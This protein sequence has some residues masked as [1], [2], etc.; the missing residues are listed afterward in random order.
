M[1]LQLEGSTG[2][3]FSIYVNGTTLSFSIKEFALVTSLKC[4]G[5][6]DNFQFD[7][8]VPNRIVETYFGGANLVKKKDLLTCFAEKNWGH[9]NDGDAIK[10]VV[11]Y[12]IHIFIFSSEKDTTTIPRLHFD[13]VE[14]GRFSDY[15]WGIKAF[16]NLIKSISKKMD[17]QKKYYRIARMPLAMQVWF[18]E[19]CSN[20]DPKIAL[21]VDNRVPRILN[22]RSTINQPTYAYMMNGMFTDQG[23]MIVYNDIQPSDT[24]L[25]IIQIPPVGVDVEN[26]PTPTH[27]EKSA[28]DSNDFTATPHLQSKK[29]HAASV[30]PSSSPPHKKRKEQIIDPSNVETQSK[31]PPVGGSETGENVLHDKKPVDSKTE[32][33]S[34][35]SKDLYSSKEYML[36]EHLQDN[37]Q[38]E[39]VY[40][41]KNTIGRRDDGHDAYVA[42]EK[43]KLAKLVPLYLSI[44]GFYRDKQGIDWSHDSAYT[45]KSHTDP[46]DVV[47]ISN[48]PQQKA[49]SMYVFN[50]HAWIVGCMLRHT[51]S[52]L[53]TFGE[54]PQIRFDANLL[55]QRYGALL[56]DYAMRKIDTDAISKNEAPSKIARQI[57]ESDS[58]L[59]IVLE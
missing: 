1:A 18:Y 56:W 36:S 20:V 55:R 47:F 43:D 46:F 50:H 7:E 53:S 19:C 9:D 17:S 57:T 23:N 41:R 42:S 15:P 54:V 33:V 40:E 38:K 29:K 25:A 45:D 49:G 13:L 4:V 30:G 24:E 6:L 52:C 5:D 27:S 31:I 8:K 39:R 22:W 11:F 2:D 14:S 28:E 51:Q 10:I 32:E 58:S 44:S 48:L 34:S 16:E 59:K 35:L 21:C 26:S 3:V 12:L 37:Q